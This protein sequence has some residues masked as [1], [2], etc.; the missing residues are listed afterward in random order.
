MKTLNIDSNSNKKDHALEYMEHCL[1]PS[2][3]KEVF[4]KKLM[5]R[6]ASVQ[7][8]NN[9]GNLLGIKQEKPLS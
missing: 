9:K 5:P 4:A 2:G 6:P 7:S 3:K 8:S 1:Q